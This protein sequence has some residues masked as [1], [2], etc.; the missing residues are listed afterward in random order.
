M[1]PPFF[2]VESRAPSAKIYK[3]LYFVK[4]VIGIYTYR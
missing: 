1:G 3:I 4:Y 2:F